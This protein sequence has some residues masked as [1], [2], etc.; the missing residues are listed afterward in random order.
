VLPLVNKAARAISCWLGPRM[1]GGVAPDLNGVPAFQED[2]ASQWARIDAASFLTVATPTS[3]ILRDREA[4]VS[5]DVFTVRAA[6][7]LPPLE[8]PR[9]P[10]AHRAHAFLE[11][12]RLH[13]PLLFGKLVIR[14]R[15]HACRHLAP[16][17]LAR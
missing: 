11:V 15:A 17:R 8:I 5:K 1:G 9:A 16:Q 2:T 4:I 13:Q 14:R 10:F 12:V 6:T 7:Q 3:L